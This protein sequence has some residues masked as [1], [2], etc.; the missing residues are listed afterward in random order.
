MRA[1]TGRQTVLTIWQS[2]GNESIVLFVLDQKRRQI[3]PTSTLFSLIH[4]AGLLSRTGR[5]FG[6]VGLQEKLA[7]I[8]QTSKCIMD[9]W[10]KHGFEMDDQL[11]RR[12]YLT[13]NSTILEIKRHS[14]LD[15]IRHY[16]VIRPTSRLVEGN[17][18]ARHG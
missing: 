13:M 4:M 10:Y 17:A 16:E 14:T 1:I 18:G 11:I 9:L 12:P 5:L 8:R 3:A 15:P 2:V 6:S 7:F